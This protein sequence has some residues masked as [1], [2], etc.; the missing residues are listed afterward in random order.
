M[1]HQHHGRLAEAA[2]IYRAILAQHPNHADTLH[3]LGIIAVMTAQPEQ[4]VELIG[5]AIAVNPSVAGYHT[6][7]GIALATL[8]RKEDA[9]AAHRKALELD[10]RLFNARHNLGSVLTSIGQY[11][12]AISSFEIAAQ[13]KPDDPNTHN[14]LGVALLLSQRLDEAFAE[15]E[16][17]K[18]LSP[19][20]PHVF[21]HLGH[22]HLEC[23][24]HD[25]ALACFD[26]ALALG[27][28]VANRLSTKIFAMHCHPG[29]D[30]LAILKSAKQWEALVTAPLPRPIPPHPNDRTVD[31]KLRIGYVSPDFR[32]HPVGRCILP[33]LSH[34]DRGQFEIYCYSS[35]AQEDSTTAML[36]QCADG[37]RDI[38]PLPDERV[39]EMIRNDRIDILVDL[40]LHT[41]GHRLSV[42][43]RKPAPVQISYLGYC[44]TTG[45]SAMDYRLSDPYVDPPEVDLSVYCEQTIRLPRNYLCYAPMGDAPEVSPPPCLSGGA[46]TF[47]CLNNFMK[48]SAVSLDLWARILLSV[49]KSRLILHAK[50]G[51]HLDR[52]RERFERGG[53][54][55]S[56][57][58]FVGKQDWPQ[59]IQT[60][61]RI[62]IALDPFPYNGGITTCEAL[63]MGVPVITLSGKTAVGRVGRS[64]LS[65]VGLPEMIAPSP[66]QY[67]QLA[68]DLANNHDRLKQLRAEL[69]PRLQGSPL[70]DG[71]QLARDI[72]SVYRNAWRQFCTG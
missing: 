30:S 15:F 58:E 52:V 47:G 64:I 12:E 26:R 54:S 10:P 11:D 51:R 24:Q 38:C 22:A 48:C 60:Y 46:I 65:N 59:Y 53:V 5:R 25:E 43:A 18:R 42:F 62:D 69:R 70:M 6:D 55:P 57:L 14:C 61:A 20:S 33:L 19:N 36:R 67:L 63:W 37:W 16:E 35:A 56:R 28:P 2:Q 66:E 41:V 40:A 68:V 8:G 21:M 29:Y 17:A 9:I 50:P 3:L 27:P 1:D 23:A 72:E 7:L 44:S 13:L 4:A 32:N 39:A 71:P 45:L 49:P 31:R 34:H